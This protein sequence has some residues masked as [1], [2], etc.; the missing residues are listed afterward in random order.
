MSAPPPSDSD[1]LERARTGDQQALRMLVERYE[2]RVAATV[3][4]MMGRGAEADDVGQE[5]FIRFYRAMGRFRGDASLGTYITR[6]AI[7]ESLKA[8]KKRQRWTKRFF[9]PDDDDSAIRN[10]AVDDAPPQED[11]DRERVIRRALDRLTPDHRAVVI[12]RILEEHS[13]KETAA[14]L[15]I[16][17]GTVMSRLKRALKALQRDAHSLID[18]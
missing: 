17:E 3:I 7:N 12:L 10:A 15:G 2:G 4:G 5:T 13:T 1:L 6:I 11:A 16:P 18:V 14:I 9:S 8:L